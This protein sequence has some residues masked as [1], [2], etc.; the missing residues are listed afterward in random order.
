MSFY[1]FLFILNK[2]KPNSF[3]STLFLQLITSSLANNHLRSKI[4]LATAVSHYILVIHEL[5]SC[6]RYAEGIFLNTQFVKVGSI[7]I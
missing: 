5:R 7:E 1:D 2:T 3:N 6:L 4:V